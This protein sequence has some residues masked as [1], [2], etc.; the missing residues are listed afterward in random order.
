MTRVVFKIG[1]LKP[2]EK[3]L[4]LDDLVAIK[5]KQKI[6]TRIEKTQPPSCV[7]PFMAPVG[8]IGIIRGKWSI[9]FHRVEMKQKKL[10]IGK[11]SKS[12]FQKGV[13]FFGA[14][15]IMVAN[16]DYDLVAIASS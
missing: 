14:I 9:A 11:S 2:I 3:C 12:L 10:A 13:I 5:K 15:E 1:S 8:V 4:F 7:V 6:G 16:G